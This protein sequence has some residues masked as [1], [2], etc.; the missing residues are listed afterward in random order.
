MNEDRMDDNRPDDPPPSPDSGR[1][2]RAPPT[3]DLEATEVTKPAADAAGED[4][5]SS[6]DTERASRSRSALQPFWIA[7]LT[8]ALA[9]ALVIVIA[10]A[11]GWPG[12]TAQPVAENNASA[13]ATL[14]S[15]LA[16]LEARL[17][18]P[19]GVDPALAARLDALDKSLAS[20][21]N[22][23]SAARAQSQKL[24][25]ELDAAKS[26]SSSSAS[27]PAAPDLS[28]IEGRLTDIERALRSQSDNLAQANAKPADDTA[29]RRL[30]VASML[31]ISVRQ[32]EPFAQ[33]LNAA[34]ALAPDPQLLKPLEN[35]A[36]SG[37]PNPAA[38]CRELL[39]LVPKLEPPAPQNATTG[40]GIVEHLK[41]GAAKLVRIER[42]DAAG[43]DRG[44]IVARLTAAALRNDVAEA[45]R[46]LNALE[47]ADRAPAQGW[48]E[49]ATERDAALSASRKFAN[50][51]MAALAKPAP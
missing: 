17:S 43:N 13:I 27:A 28:P 26:A 44:A 16:D 34:K 2:K 41:A 29:L 21:R 14:S 33:A 51:A 3:I 11:L 38:L 7:G 30:V 39:T 5:T 42:T 32:G 31:E 9:A 45:R 10:T 49:K 6:D 35:F 40:T 15:R 25:A 19:P 36:S 12:E 22:D 48:L 8:G 46:E 50:E 23:L 4:A 24:A 37:V 18:K 20:L 1:P 47:P